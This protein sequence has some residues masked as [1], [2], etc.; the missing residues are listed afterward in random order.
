[1]T[2]KTKRNAFKPTDVLTVEQAAT[3][4]GAAIVDT[5]K[6]R[7]AIEDDAAARINGLNA[8]L[9]TRLEGIAAKCK[10]T[11]DDKAAFMTAFAESMGRK[12][13]PNDHAYWLTFLALSNGVANP[14]APKTA[15]EYGRACDD[16]MRAKGILPALTDAEIKRREGMERKK[17]ER[18]AAKNGEIP[19]GRP[20]GSASSEKNT[21]DPIVAF[22]ATVA[23]PA[24]KVNRDLQELLA[25][26]A[27]ND[28]TGKYLVSV[29]TAAA[30]ERG[31]IS[32][33]DAE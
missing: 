19:M 15:Q 27:E 26:F 24:T 20:V 33:D 18:E 23:K 30:I 6:A 17:A 8:P 16:M 21:A 31:W 9:F 22:A 25:V 10:A 1:M 14:D 32:T 11:S 12:S 29:L 7:K 4:F 13:S 3:Q 5:S 2:T 28:K